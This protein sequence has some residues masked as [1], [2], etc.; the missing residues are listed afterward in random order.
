MVPRGGTRPPEALGFGHGGPDGAMDRL[1]PE[2][3]LLY[4]LGGQRE[5]Q[6]GPVGFPSGRIHLFLPVV[7]V[8]LGIKT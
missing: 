6:A 8:L 3:A 5:I 2:V 7:Q 4:L 1:C